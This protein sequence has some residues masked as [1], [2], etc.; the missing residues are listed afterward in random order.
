[1]TVLPTL[2]ALRPAAAAVVLAVLVPLVTFSESAIKG[3]MSG[4][5]ERC[6]IVLEKEQLAPGKL[7]VTGYM[8]G[9]APNALPLTFSANKPLILNVKFLSSEGLSGASRHA[10]LGLHPLA[11]ETCPGA[12]CEGTVYT[13]GGEPRINFTLGDLSESFLYRFQIR[14]ANPGTLDDLGVFVVYQTGLKDGVCRVENASL[15][16]WPVRVGPLAKILASA[17]LLLV[18]G[19]AVTV[20]TGW[21]KKEGD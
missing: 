2:K 15:F 20:L 16:N 3:L 12:L 9:K 1:M 17:V 13:E 14:L 18:A 6:L 7:M 8:R 11:G 21:R 10:N 19:Y 5:L 4:W